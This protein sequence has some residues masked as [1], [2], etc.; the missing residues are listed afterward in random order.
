MFIH[1]A[2]KCRKLCSRC[3]TCVM[4]IRIQS[5]TERE[6]VLMHVLMKSCLV[7]AAC[8]RWHYQESV[9]LPGGRQTAKKAEGAAA[10]APDGRGACHMSDV[11]LERGDLWNGLR[12]AH[13]VPGGCLPQRKCLSNGSKWA[14]HKC[15][16]RRPWPLAPS[17]F[18]RFIARKWLTVK[19][20][21]YLSVFLVWSTLWGDYRNFG[22]LVSSGFCTDSL[23]RVIKTIIGSES[24]STG[25]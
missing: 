22:G 16:S 17:V 2:F 6:L 20:Q 7:H 24:T 1:L 19:T 14:L 9:V 3:T 12:E 8:L 13:V 10:R 21:A 23:S 15:L 5:S 11:H 25:F 18:V 4:H